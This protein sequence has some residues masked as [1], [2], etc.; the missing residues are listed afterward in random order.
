[1]QISI[2]KR[3][4]NSTHVTIKGLS[5]GRCGCILI[6]WDISGCF[7]G[8]FKRP[9]KPLGCFLFIITF[10]FDEGCVQN[11]NVPGLMDVPTAM[12]SDSTWMGFCNGCG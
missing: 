4:R 5:V 6:G 12:G 8:R 11:G 2:N 7:T 3:R 10:R 1:M 9:E